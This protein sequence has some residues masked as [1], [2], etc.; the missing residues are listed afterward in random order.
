M[1]RGK[2][3][4]TTNISTSD[5]RLLQVPH[6][7]VLHVTMEEVVQM[8]VIHLNADVLLDFWEIDVKLKVKF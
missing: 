8:L 3:A 7:L 2:K 5:I 6:V 4:T 1:R